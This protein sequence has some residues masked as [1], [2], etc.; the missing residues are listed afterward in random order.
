MAIVEAFF[1]FLKEDFSSVS[2]DLFIAFVKAFFLL[3]CASISATLILFVV[4]TSD[5]FRFIL[6][7]LSLISSCYVSFFVNYG[8]L[9][10]VTSDILRFILFVNY[11]SLTN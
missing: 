4:V 8:L 1:S 7:K 9:V 11:R 10:V 5:I 6:C 2:C 3:I